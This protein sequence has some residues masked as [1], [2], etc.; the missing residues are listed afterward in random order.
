MIIIKG[1]GIE[2]RESGLRS[3]KLLAGG[4][5][6]PGWVNITGRYHALCTIRQY[7]LIVLHNYTYVLHK[8]TYT[9]HKLGGIANKMAPLVRT[10]DVLVALKY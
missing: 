8:Q 4:P 1:C 10:F 3:K 9:H 5:N 7:K 6:Y 2:T